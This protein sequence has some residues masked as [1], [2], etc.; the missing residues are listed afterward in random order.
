MLVYRG[1]DNIENLIDF[2]S[3]LIKHS[4]KIEE[5]NFDPN[6][7]REVISQTYATHY[8][9]YN[10]ILMPYY[11]ALLTIHYSIYQEQ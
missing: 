3:Q 9:L 2:Y 5:S 10:D 7:I 6:T 4:N 8:H 11:L 1:H